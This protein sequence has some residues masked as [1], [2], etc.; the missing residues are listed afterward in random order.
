MDSVTFSYLVKLWHACYKQ[1]LQHFQMCTKSHQSWFAI[2]LGWLFSDSS[3]HIIQ[4]YLSVF[5]SNVEVN[6]CNCTWYFW[7]VL[8]LTQS[9]K[10]LHIHKLPSNPFCSSENL[11]PIWYSLHLQ[12]FSVWI[13]VEHSWQI[14]QNHTVFP[15]ESHCC[16]AIVYGKDLNTS[17]LMI[18]TN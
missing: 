12:I 18:F 7:Q 17:I 15:Q 10:G 8:C 3:K 16:W 4:S 14:Q 1:Y 11:C 2:V 9:L 5:V 6:V 13:R